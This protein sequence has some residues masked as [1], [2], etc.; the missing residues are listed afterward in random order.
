RLTLLKPDRPQYKEFLDALLE[1]YRKGKAIA[2]DK[3]LTEASRC[4]RVEQLVDAVCDCTGARFADETKPTDEAEKDFFFDLTHEIV[5]LMSDDELFTFVIHPEADGTNNIS[6]RQLRDPAQD[7]ATGQTNKTERG[8]RRRTVITSVLDSLRA[9]VPKLTLK[10]ALEE[11]NRWQQTGISCFRR[12][13]NK[14]KLP[15]LNLPDKIQSP[16]EL[17][18]PLNDTG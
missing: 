14:L 8:A 15:A 11:L 4:A 12:L 6:E 13:V 17:L 1:I 9:H 3:R 18:V 16:L 2:S 5:R 10:T 7:R